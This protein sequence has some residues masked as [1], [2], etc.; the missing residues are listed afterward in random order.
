MI[1]QHDKDQTPLSEIL[2]FYV[3]NSLFIFKAKTN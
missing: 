1:C 2:L 3:F